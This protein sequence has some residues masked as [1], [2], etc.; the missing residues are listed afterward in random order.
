MAL[1]E[2]DILDGRFEIGRVAATGGMGVVF[3]G[4]DRQTGA[5]VAI[6]TLR[7]IEGAERFRRE[8]QVLSALKHPGIV[9]YLGHGRTEE[10]FYLVMEWLEGEDLGARLEGAEVTLEESVKLGAQIASALGA[11]HAQGIVHRDVKPS[12]VFLADWR[13]DRIKLLDLGIARQIGSQSLTE[14]GTV[15]GTPAYMAPEQARSGAEI[16]ARADVYAL[17]AV[18]FRCLAGRPPFEAETREALIDALLHRPAPRLGELVGVPPQV[19]DLVARMLDKDPQRRPADGRAAWA[20][21]SSLGTTSSVTVPVS[22]PFAGRDRTGS[23]GESAVRRTLSSVA[24]LPFLDM[25]AGRDQGYL[26]EGIAEELINTLTSVPGLRVAARSSSFALRAAEPDAREIG[27]RLGV[28]AVLE[29]GVRKSGE[30][31][32]ITVQLVDIG[33]GS[34][35]WSHR[36]D[37]TLDQVFEIQDQ[38]AASVA[39]ALRGIL[40]AEERDALRR[41]GT[42]AEAYEHF[43]R[44]RQLLHAFSVES[45]RS[46]EREFTRAIEID[47]LYAPAHS[48]L[49]QVYMWQLDWMG[50]GTEVRRAAD[51]ASQRALELGPELAESHVARGAYLA[52]QGDYEGAERAYRDALRVNPGSLEACYLGARACFQAGKLESS[53]ELFLRGS[54][55]SPE[56]YQ[57]LVI[58]EV[59]LIRL[60]RMEEAARVR[61]EG[62]RRIERQLQLDP[63]DSRALILGAVSLASE[64]QP[65][66]ALEWARRAIE[67]SPDDPSV[68][69]NAACMYIR[70]G[71]KED[72]LACLE[73]SFGRGLGKRDWVI[74]DPDYDAIR[75]DPRFQAMLAKLR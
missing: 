25:S 35:R 13:L 23:G 8:V 5:L 60:G 42:R 32:R 50:G 58:A 39:S 65:Q 69:T 55:I 57:C 66:R 45:C 28:D 53:V 11:A 41:P 34:P 73:G 15:L 64:G 36:F 63:R 29:G 31:L 16:D 33:G 54:E 51:L 62:L 38:I 46:A 12:N 44:G 56:D 21:L 18:L 68:L 22:G 75:D 61:Q 19:E 1:R 7:S 30:R 4:T 47:P 48:G 14:V 72:A 71:R 6:K 59:P 49:T 20:A 74:R 24:V 9:T 3:R 70:V 10:E 26:C 52:M 40:S 27:R 43:L 17:G 2:G 67:V 37:G